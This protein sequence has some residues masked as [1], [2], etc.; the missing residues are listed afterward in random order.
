[1][2]SVYIVVP[3][4]G[5]KHLANHLLT[6]YHSFN[7]S[8]IQFRV[9]V[10]GSEKH[11]SRSVARGLMY[12]E[13]ENLP[14]DRKYDVGFQ[15]CRQF[16]PDAVALVGSDDFITMDYFE[17]AMKQIESGCGMTGFYDFYIADWIGRRILYWGGYKGER[18]GQSIGAGRVFSRKALE[19]MEWKPFITDGSYFNMS[20]DDERA[21][22]KVIQS[23]FE[24]NCINMA[25]IGCRYWAVKTGNEVNHVSAFK[26]TIDLTSNYMKKLFYQ[27]VDI[28]FP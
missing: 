26:D 9:V 8:S 2:K 7:S 25:N 18:Q 4:W 13:T 19:A 21:E 20:K 22:S 10:V 28:T 12:V 5:R 15:A 23:G 17:W 6:Y 16:E 1:M 27:D 3:I 14:L 11:V 24:V